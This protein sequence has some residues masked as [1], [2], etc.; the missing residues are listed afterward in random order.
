MN[1]HIN[2]IQSFLFKENEWSEEFGDAVWLAYHLVQ[3][4]VIHFKDLNE[5]ERK[6][7]WLLFRSAVKQHVEKLLNE[8]ESSWS[9]EVGNGD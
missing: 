4:R 6:T 5:A 8:L 1:D 3:R 7:A 9:M 2:Q